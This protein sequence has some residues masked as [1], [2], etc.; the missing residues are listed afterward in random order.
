MK[1]ELSQQIFEK[2]SNIIFHEYPS[3]GNKVVPR[4]KADR[5]A[6][7]MKIFSTIL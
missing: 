6:D 7:M 3:S 1:L 5:H 2:Y 4:R